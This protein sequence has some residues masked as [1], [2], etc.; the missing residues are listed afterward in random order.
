MSVRNLTCMVL[1]ALLY[2][3]AGQPYAPAPP[4]SDSEPMP[5]VAPIDRDPPTVTDRD[6]PEADNSAVATTSLLASASDALQQNDHH[7]AIAYLQRAIRIDPRDAELWVQLSAAHLQDGN[8]TAAHQHV[9]KAIA[10]A[11]RDERLVR[12]A[13]LALADVRA[14]EGNPAEAAAIR[15]RYEVIRG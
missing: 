14:A 11:G 6:N 1:A 8:L 10:L 5:D 4:I 3:C 2:G 13:W 12:L 15:R 7:T 9:R